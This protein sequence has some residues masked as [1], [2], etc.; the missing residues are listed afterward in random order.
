MIEFVC[1]RSGSG[2]SEYIAE[3]IREALSSIGNPLQ[4]G[5]PKKLYLLVPE[6]QAVVWESRVARC[7]PPSAALSLEIV[8][9]TPIQF[10]K[11]PKWLI[12]P[13][14]IFRWGLNRSFRPFLIF[15]GL[16]IVHFSHFHFSSGLKSLISAVSDFRWS[17]PS[18]GSA[19]FNRKITKNKRLSGWR[20]AV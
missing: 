8:N 16:Q 17:F 2:K 19:I 4:G 13:V 12:S 18:I 3:K 11:R 10:S 5:S 14:F 15:V 7:L 9:F 1:G 20:S 6:Q